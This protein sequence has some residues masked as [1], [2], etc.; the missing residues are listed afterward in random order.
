MEARARALLQRAG[1][2]T[3]LRDDELRDIMTAS[4]PES[5]AG[6]RASPEGSESSRSAERSVLE[7]SVGDMSLPSEIAADI[8][9]ASS[10]RHAA[11]GVGASVMGVHLHGASAAAAAAAAQMSDLIRRE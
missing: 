7:A 1:V 3:Q 11:G 5:G 4:S 10:T 8:A 2:R 6:S 9:A